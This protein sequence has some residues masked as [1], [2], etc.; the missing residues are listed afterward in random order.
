MPKVDNFLAYQA[1]KFITGANVHYVKTWI[2]CYE[3]S[4]PGS[5]RRERYEKLLRDF[6]TSNALIRAAQEQVK[7]DA[8]RLL[9]IG[10]I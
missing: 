5:A 1:R 7:R 3:T 9:N 2:F 6:V 8:R 10:S 4:V